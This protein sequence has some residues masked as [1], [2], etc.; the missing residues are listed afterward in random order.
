MNEGK[1]FLDTNILVY[2]YDSSAGRKH[3]KARDI[4]IEL[5]DSGLGMLSTQVLQEFYVTVTQKIPKPMKRNAARQ[6]IQDLM[7]WE[8]IIN[9]GGTILAAIDL[10]ETYRLSFWD[11]MIVQSAL[12]GGAVSLLSEDLEAGLKI[13]RM[14][15]VNPF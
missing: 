13:D 5:W 10:Q 11:A 15:I 9:D 3:Q 2:A 14:T 4:M 12:K 1:K 8:V 7:C 6:I